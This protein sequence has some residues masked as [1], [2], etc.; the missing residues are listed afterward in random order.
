MIIKDKIINVTQPSLPPLEDFIPY[1]EKIWNKKWLTNNGEFHKQFETA[2]AEY[3]G[4]KYVSLFCNGMIALQIGLQ[5]LKVTGE[6]ITT[7]YTFAATTHAIYWNRC[8]PVFC[9]INEDDFNINVEL[10]ESLITPSTTAIMPVHIYGNPCDN[11]KL[12]QICDTYGLKLIY[13]AAHAFDVQINGNSIL[14]WGDLSMLSFHATKCFN[15]FEGGALITNDI[16][17]KKRVDFLKNFGF[18]GETTIVAPGSNGKM[19]EFSAALGC[20]QLKHIDAEIEKA[21]KVAEYYRHKLVNKRGIVFFADIPNVKHNYSYFP[22]LVN[23]DIYCMSRDE[24]Y[25]K[26]KEN[27]IFSRRYFYPLTSQFSSY[28]HFSSAE[29]GKLPIAEKIAKHVLC[30]PIYPDIDIALL[31]R[32]CNIVNCDD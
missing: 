25:L 32:I 10:I 4:V 13:D 1:L 22:I 27:N 28:R 8:T 26:L 20:I 14:N 12:Q 21:K 23:E 24:L 16:K 2:L 19:S 9:D 5:A 3:L 30:L 31:R 15:T 18:A 11:E 17:L 29:K 7:P 6:V